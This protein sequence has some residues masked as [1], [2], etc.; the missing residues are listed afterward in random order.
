MR[1]LRP[2]EQ[3]FEAFVRESEPRLRQALVAAFGSELGRE[4]TLE[5]LMW[6]WT[7]WDRLPALANARG[8]LY[9]VGQSYAYRHVKS[10]D[11]S[12][13]WD[14]PDQ[15]DLTPWVE[16]QLRAALSELSERQRLAVVLCHGLQWTQVEV[17]S[18]LDLSPSSVQKHCE[19]GMQALRLTLGASSNDIA[20]GR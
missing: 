18:L 14:P 2:D 1:A 9:R 19:R 4:S 20:G 10:R 8:Y 5:A 6:A 15:R 16:P 11:R 17:A 3:E 7:H 12:L 13:R